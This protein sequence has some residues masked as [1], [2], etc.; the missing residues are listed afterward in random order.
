MAQTTPGADAATASAAPPAAA[1]ATQEARLQAARQL[2]IQSARLAANTRCTNVA[3][4]D[5][6]GISPVTDFLVLA[7][8]TSPRQMKTVCDDLE[9]MAE[10]Q[11]SKAFSRVGDDSASWTCIDFI[12]VVVHV[13]SQEARSYYD[14]DGLWG[15]AKI[16]EWRDPAQG[17]GPTKP[18]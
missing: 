14:L 15:D 12:D 17:E 16:V 1:P 10:A 6:S 7:T 5:V 13:F 8:G 18:S 11:N 3:V 2:A 4:L 9:E